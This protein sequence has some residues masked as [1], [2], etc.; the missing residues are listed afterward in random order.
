MIS[1]IILAAGSSQRMGSPKALLKIGEKTFLQYIVDAL[2]SARIMDIVIVLGAEA[3]KIQQSL[4][5][6]DGKVVV[7][8]DWQKGQLTSIISGLNNLDMTLTDLEEIHGA[9]ICPVDHPLLTQSLLVE[10]L[11][12]FWRSKKKI[13]V[14]TFNNKRG[15]PVIFGRELFNE[16]CSSSID[17]GAKE[18]VHNHPDETFEVSVEEEGVLINIDTPEDYEKFILNYGK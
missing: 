12:G 9:M 17:I 6:F 2:H 4:T 7:N 13:I 1:G 14:P 8:N 10:L 16:I 15:H 11:Q 3:E 5:W 18:V